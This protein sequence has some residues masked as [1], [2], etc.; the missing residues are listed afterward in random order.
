MTF[1]ATSSI[2]Q[3]ER[4]DIVNGTLKILNDKAYY[5]LLMNKIKILK[6]KIGN[7]GASNMAAKLIEKV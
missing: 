6:Q 7:P 3:I 5:D 4:V 2:E 1:S